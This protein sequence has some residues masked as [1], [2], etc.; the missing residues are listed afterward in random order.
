MNAASRPPRGAILQSLADQRV[1]VVGASGAEGVS[2]LLFLAGHCGIEGLI[3]HDFAADPRAFAK[4][5]R[6]N[7]TAWERPVRE[8]MLTQLRRLP[9]DL[10]LGDDYLGGIEFAQVILASQNWFNYPA[11]TNEIPRALARGAQLIGLADLALDLFEGTRIG[12]TGSNGKSTTAA[13]IRHILTTGLG[14]GR[15]VLQGGNDRAQQVS[16]E[17][18]QAAGLGG[19]LLWEVSNRHLR[20]RSPTVDI[21]VITNITRNHIED[22]GT[23]ENYVR[24]KL[25]LAH[26]VSAGGQVVLSAVDS[27]CRRHTQSIRATGATLWRFG[28]APP[29]GFGLDGLAWVDEDGWACLRRPRSTEIQ[30]VGRLEEMALPGIHNRLN[31][32]AAICAAA[33][34]GI[35]PARIG[36]A[37]PTVE[38][39]PGRLEPVAE[40]EGIRWIYDIQATTA[41]AAEQGIRAIASTGRRVV[42]IVGGD[43]K[44]M[45]YSGMAEA[46][47]EFCDVILALPGTG[48]DALMLQLDGRVPVENFHDLDSLIAHAA[49]S[50]APGTAIL[51]SP[52]CAFFHSRYIEPGATFARRVE[53]ALNKPS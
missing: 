7:N 23:F 53:A 11:N 18:V 47:A 44:G 45:D 6:K 28:A 21:A 50:A 10:R 36:E 38:A 40:R 1:H 12:V 30:R 8:E 32:L 52:G 16:L 35:E 19:V 5:F 48:T 41:P 25:R 46:A 24:A 31:M 15:Q 9:I 14:R 17:A 39:L 22:H 33:A 49:E 51:L 27:M 20:D 37:I 29:P 26:G 4:S 34:A 13:M 43:D 3:A 42:L 2:L